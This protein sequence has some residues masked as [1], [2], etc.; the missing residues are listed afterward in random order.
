MRSCGKPQRA[1][2]LR[3]GSRNAHLSRN[4]KMRQLLGHSRHH[5]GIRLEQNFNGSRIRIVMTRE[6]ASNQ[7]GSVLVEMAIVLPVLLLLILGGIDLDLMT[8]S[9][10]ALNY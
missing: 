5:K 9:K 8:T 3:S 7:R 2:I 1:Q 6:N 10:S 4:M